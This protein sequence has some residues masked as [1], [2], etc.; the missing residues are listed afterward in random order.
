MTGDAVPSIARRF[1]AWRPTAFLLLAC[2][3]LNLL[4]SSFSWASSSEESPSSLTTHVGS[5][6]LVES[7]DSV[8]VLSP[9]ATTSQ[10]FSSVSVSSLSSASADGVSPSVTASLPSKHLSSSSTQPASSSPKSGSSSPRSA[11]YRLS[12]PRLAPHL[13]NARPPPSSLSSPSAVSSSLDIPSSS[14]SS[15]SSFS[16]PFFPSSPSLPSSSSASS[17]F[18]SSSRGQV[19]ITS[20]AFSSS[21][22]ISRNAS[23]PV[24]FESFIPRSLSANATVAAGARPSEASSSAEDPRGVV[25]DPFFLLDHGSMP[26]GYPT[27][28]EAFR[29]MNQLLQTYGP[30]L[31]SEHRI[32]HSFEGRPI[33]AF[34]VG[35]LLKRRGG[36]SV[37]PSLS[38]PVPSPLGGGSAAPGQAREQRS[39]DESPLSANGK[40]KQDEEFP[41]ILL[42]GLHHAREPMSMTMCIYFMARLLRDCQAGEAEAVY[43]MHLREFWVVPFLNPDA[44]VAIEKTGNTQLRKNR[45]RFS[46]EGR[47]AHAKLEDEGVD[48]NRNYAFHF[49]LAQSEGSDDYGGPFPFSEPETAAV[50]FLVEQYQRSSQPTPSPPASPSSASSSELHRMIDFSPPQSS[51]F[52]EDLGRFE[53]ALNFHTYGEVWTRPFNCCKEMPLPR[54]AQ[55]AFEELQV[56]LAIPT[57]NSAPN[58][59]VLGYPTQGEADDW[60]LHEHNVLSTS[61]EIGWEEGSF[62]QTVGKQRESLEVNFARIVTAAVKAGSE[63]GVRLS[64]GWKHFPPSDGEKE[65]GKETVSK[66]E[67]GDDFLREPDGEEERGFRRSLRRRIRERNER[68]VEEPADNTTS[69][70]AT[71]NVLQ[72]AVPSDRLAFVEETLKQK[73]WKSILELQANATVS[74]H[75][76]EVVNT[77]LLPLHGSATILFLTGLPLF[78][79]PLVASPLSALFTSVE[80]AAA[81]APSPLRSRLEPRF[82]GSRSKIEL[83]PPE[84][85][86]TFQAFQSY[87]SSLSPSRS[88]S[89]PSSRSPSPSSSRSPSPSPSRSPS[90]SSGSNDLRSGVLDE[91]RADEPAGEKGEDWY[92]LAFDEKWKTVFPV[93]VVSPS[94]R[95]VEGDATEEGPELP[96]LLVE[97]PSAVRGRDFDSGDAGVVRVHLLLLETKSD[98][99]FP[100]EFS[101]R[102]ERRPSQERSA[103]SRDRRRSQ[104]PAVGA[105]VLETGPRELKLSPQSGEAS[106]ARTVPLFCRCGAVMTEAEEADL[107]GVEHEGDFKWISLPLFLENNASSRLCAASLRLASRR[108]SSASAASSSVSF[109]LASYISSYISA[110]LSSYFSPYIS[111][112]FSSLET[113]GGRNEGR[114]LEGRWRG[115]CFLGDLDAPLLYANRRSSV[116]FAALL[117]LTLFLVLGLALRLRFRSRGVHAAAKEVLADAG[118]SGAAAWL[119]A[120]TYFLCCCLQM[121]FRRPCRQRIPPILM[122]EGGTSLHAT[123]GRRSCQNPRSAPRLGC[124]SQAWREKSSRR[125]RNARSLPAVARTGLS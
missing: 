79:S 91:E 54:W 114:R 50:K 64:L 117:L 31:I 30:S 28:D 45:R 78:S 95:F 116:S 29:M 17:S 120:Q 14:S 113:P 104:R 43:L 19:A 16:S 93:S 18:S 52:L 1:R 86:R 59:A 2:P 61:P 35:G 15:S 9:L 41:E 103:S 107:S 36:A 3:Y 21:S 22:A 102:S 48:L 110:S 65:M 62:W 84:A 4:L 63:L 123:R 99:A 80:D 10:L 42:T 72:N 32:G 90:P 56:S 46:S 124:S 125:N 60:L 67:G 122:D 39:S 24:S 27:Y 106:E 47:P 34:R 100:P 40:R 108:S 33:V 83:P 112:V 73:G 94:S 81:S 98:A 75:V 13:S 121:F 111:A 68:N 88:P 58:I 118:I 11:A 8:E 77:G 57:L 51:S 71:R 109:S 38:P 66:L 76:I 82:T 105:C 20:F 97:I 25:N 6:D 26:Y 96:G 12:L 49:L 89:S 74:M 5:R 44:Y 115:D 23:V 7:A 53:V 101:P 85:L 70:G 92:F 55:R 69:T 119:R 37:S 87:K